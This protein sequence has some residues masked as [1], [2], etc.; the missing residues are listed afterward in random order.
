M[1]DDVFAAPTLHHLVHQ[2]R[3]GGRGRFEWL[4]RQHHLQRRLHAHQPRQPLRAAK[5]WD[6]AQAQ[7]R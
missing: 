1:R 3:L 4:G 5:P 7:L 2:P 6:D